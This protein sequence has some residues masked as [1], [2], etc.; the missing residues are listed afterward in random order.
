VS[1]Q[2]K[3]KIYLTGERF[4]TF[5]YYE[6]T[7]EALFSDALIWRATESASDT[8]LILYKGD[9]DILRNTLYLKFREEDFEHY[10]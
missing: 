7:R 3:A 8:T 9:S 2:I 5:G 10:S 6:L 1:L 4:K